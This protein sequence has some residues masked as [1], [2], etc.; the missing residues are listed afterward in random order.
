M[1]RIAPLALPIPFQR[2]PDSGV[3]RSD[4]AAG[5][6]SS[7][8]SVLP[9]DAL[10]SSL[11]ARHD[12][13][14]PE[15]QTAFLAAMRGGASVAVAAHGVGMSRESAYRLRRNPRATS[16]AADWA[17]IEAERAAG[18]TIADVLAD[19]DHIAA[20]YAAVE[21]GLAARATRPDFD[22][23][24]IRRLTALGKRQQKSD[25]P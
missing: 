7:R 6:S 10:R 23:F 2:F 13:W 11:C 20:V 25:L 4:S 15:R 3:F 21:R 19:P 14:L 16:F 17:A 22:G 9:P 1:T 12:G 8:G 18:P 5:S 24:L